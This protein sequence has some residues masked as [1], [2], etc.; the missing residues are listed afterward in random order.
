[1]D[2]AWSPD[3]Q[4]LAFASGPLAAETLFVMNRDGTNVSVRA[5]SPWSDRQPAWSPDG[6][7][8]AFTSARDAVGTTGHVR[9]LFVMNADGSDP[10]HVASSID[11]I[12]YSPSWSPDG[13]RIAVEG[14]PPGGSQSDIYV[15]TL[16]TGDVRQVT[17]TPDEDNHPTWSPDGNR[18]AFS[19][20][21]GNVRHILSVAV[22]GSDLRP[23]TSGTMQDFE[24]A[25][26]PV[27]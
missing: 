7:L 16:A 6:T 14:R 12:A 8:I 4:L 24:P 13:T 1:M 25:F 26:R 2:P 22:D 3:G 21:S 20:R 11:L 5:P 18:I 9:R 10:H 23:I 17:A 27:P 19:R 15:I